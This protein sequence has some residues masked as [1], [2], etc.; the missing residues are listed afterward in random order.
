METAE[1][2]AQLRRDLDAFATEGKTDVPV[3]NLNNYLD[4]MEKNATLSSEGRKIQSA[5]ALAHYDATAAQ[6]REMFKAVMDC[7]KDAINSAILINGGAV[8]VIMAFLGNAVGKLNTGTLIQNISAPLFTFGVG[9]FLSSA[10]F[11]V[12]YISQFLY[13]SDRVKT[14][15]VFNA[16]SWFTTFAALSAFVWGV[17]QTYTAVLSSLLPG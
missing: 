3:S 6:Q 16:L 17:W 7:G 5:H 13:A 8:V 11:G 15:H 9:V 4:A 2:I 14:G 1:F 12:R 10:A